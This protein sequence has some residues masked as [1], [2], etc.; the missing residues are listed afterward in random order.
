MTGEIGFKSD[1]CGKI[2]VNALQFGV[3]GMWGQ[4]KV[5]YLDPTSQ[6]TYATGNVNRWMAAFK[7]F[8]PSF[9]RRT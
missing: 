6:N 8:Y 1:A 3:G 9:P 5:I 7:G 2:G 4:D